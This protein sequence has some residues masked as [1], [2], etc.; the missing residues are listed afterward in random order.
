MQRREFITLL[1]GAAT[2]PF[3]ARAQQQPVPVMGVLSPLS[4]AAAVRNIASL[5]QGLRELGYVEGR[6]ILI[7]YRFADG[8]TERFP[9]L[10]AELVQAK[11][12]LVVVGSEAA[13]L[14]A[15]SVTAALPLVM[16]GVSDDPVRLGLVES[17]ARPG[18][19]VT[20]FLLTADAAILGKKIGLLRDAVPFI[21]RLGVILTDAPSDT[22]ELQ[23][24]PAIASQLGLQYRAFEVRAQDQIEGVFTSIARDNIQALYVSW[25]PVLN[26]RRAQV[27][28]LVAKSRLPAIYGFREFVQA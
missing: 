11:P 1:G 26:A 25:A 2:W 15:R 5:R 24:L 4:A 16:I 17:F 8:M 20:G 18:G 14:A 22:A 12:S 10:V 28:A 7:E 13:V 6:N 27:T 23:M 3:A 9:N 19:D 21:S